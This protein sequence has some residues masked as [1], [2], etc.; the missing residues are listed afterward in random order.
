[1]SVVVV[2]VVNV[3]DVSVPV[4]VMAWASAGVPGLALRGPNSVSSDLVDHANTAAQLTRC[5]HLTEP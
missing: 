4:S 3:P 1:V 2:E 5:F